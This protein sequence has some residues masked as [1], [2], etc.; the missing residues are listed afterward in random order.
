MAVSSWDELDGPTLAHPDRVRFRPSRRQTVADA[1]A[2]DSGPV[3]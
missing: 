1:A 3:C 2:R